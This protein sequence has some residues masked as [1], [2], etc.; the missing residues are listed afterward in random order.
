MGSSTITLSAL[1]LCFCSRVH[2][3]AALWCSTQFPG[4]L[5]TCNKSCSSLPGV[6]FDMKILRSIKPGKSGGYRRLHWTAGSH[7]VHLDSRMLLL[8]LLGCTVAVRLLLAVFVVMQSSWCICNHCWFWVREGGKKEGKWDTFKSSKIFWAHKNATAYSFIFL[9][10]Q[11]WS[12][13][14]HNFTAG[15]SEVLPRR[16]CTMWP[17]SVKHKSSFFQLHKALQLPVL[18][19]VYLMRSSTYTWISLKPFW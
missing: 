15:A 2:W 12:L 10:I 17:A 7:G 4:C 5:R 9:C 16:Y 14:M 18:W 13:A 11:C 1:I 19:R 3:K 6:S 8:P